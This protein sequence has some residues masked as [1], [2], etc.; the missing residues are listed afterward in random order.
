MVL[1]SSSCAALF[2]CA[3]L[4]CVEGSIPRCGGQVYRCTAAALLRKN[5][6]LCQRPCPSPSGARCAFPLRAGR[7][8]SPSA[9]EAQEQARAAA[10][11]RAREARGS[12]LGAASTAATLVS[13][14]G[15][16]VRAAAAGG[17]WLR[18]RAFPTIGHC[19]SAQATI[20]R[21]AT[22]MSQ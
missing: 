14:W 17:A 12:D 18:E 8:T 7:A 19:W 3:R 6:A 22:A 4:P 1:V 13:R 20:Q 21:R 10:E 16:V 15:R 9:H 5:S 2:T 11:R